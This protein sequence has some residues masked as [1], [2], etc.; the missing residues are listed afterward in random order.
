MAFEP[1][2]LVEPVVVAASSA[3]AAAAAAATW[4]W[5][6]KCCIMRVCL[7]TKWGGN[8]CK[9]KDEGRGHWRAFGT[10]SLCLV[11]FDFFNCL[12]RCCL[13][14]TITT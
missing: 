12:I 3:S 10:F 7:E 9:I 14:T 6:W 2:E 8:E 5:G 13:C 1:S 4:D 11:L